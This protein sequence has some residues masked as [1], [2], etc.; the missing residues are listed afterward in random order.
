[1]DKADRVDTQIEEEAVTG[2]KEDMGAI[3][4]EEATE[5][6]NSLRLHPAQMSSFIP[7]ISR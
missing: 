4:V 2:A 5:D 7:T 1:M 6:Q 3:K